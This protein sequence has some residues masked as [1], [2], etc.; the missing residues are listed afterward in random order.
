MILY[1]RIYGINIVVMA[2]VFVASKT[3]RPKSKKKPEAEPVTEPVE[4]EEVIPY[5][6][7]TLFVKQRIKRTLSIPFYKIN[8]AANITQ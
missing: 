8:N 5:C 3:I 2:S 1:K 6:D 7:P 4:E